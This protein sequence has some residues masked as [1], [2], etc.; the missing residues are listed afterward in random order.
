MELDPLFLSLLKPYALRS[1]AFLRSF[2]AS[3][4]S[5][6]SALG[7]AAVCLFP[8]I[9]PSRLE[10]ADSLTIYNASSTPRTLTVMLV[11][12]LIGVPILIAYTAYLY[13]TFAGKVVVTEES[14]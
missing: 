9:V 13:K 10:L 4:V 1:G 14:Y 11:I 6:A 12:V 3:S 8:R 7:V 2:L 5:I